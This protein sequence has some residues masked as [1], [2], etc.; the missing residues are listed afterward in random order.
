M[1]VKVPPFAL[2]L[3]KGDSPNPL[4][5]LCD[6]SPSPSVISALSVVNPLP[7]L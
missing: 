6:E 7:M 1:R 4:Y 5:A 2:S 3:S